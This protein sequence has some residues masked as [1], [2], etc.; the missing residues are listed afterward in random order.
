MT[1]ISNGKVRIGIYTFPDKKTPHIC[2]Q[3]EDTNQLMDCG[4]FN[5]RDSAER[6]MKALESLVGI[7]EE[8]RA[9]FLNKGVK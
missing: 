6:F 5:S 1:A 9:V 4:H 3:Y 8:N 7:T 2:Y